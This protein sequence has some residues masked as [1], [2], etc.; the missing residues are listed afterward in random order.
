MAKPRKL[1]LNIESAHVASRVVFNGIVLADD[2]VTDTLS[3]AFVLNGWAINGANELSLGLAR[4]PVALGVLP[5]SAKEARFALTLKSAWPDGSASDETVLATYSFDGTTSPLAAGQGKEVFAQR[6]PWEAPM[7]WSWTK[8]S[9][10]AALT[11]E[12][13]EAI[14]ALLNRVRSALQEKDIATLQRLQ[15]VQV[16]EQAVALGESPT[17][18]LASYASFLQQ[19][20]SAKDWTALPLNIAALNFTAMAAGRTHLVR[21]ASRR[22]PIVCTGSEG[23]FAIEPF[24][25]KIDGQWVI[26]R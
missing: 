16:S 21:D 6:V 1:L 4:L 12:D 26:V 18:F 3:R 25:S 10:L 8:A 23:G 17:E 14:A 7:A 11:L 22:P 9:P 19:R 5:K 20:T 13:K 24:V 2:V 15:S